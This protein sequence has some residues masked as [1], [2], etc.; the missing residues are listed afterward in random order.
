MDGVGNVAKDVTRGEVE[1]SVYR[2]E[3]EPVDVVFRDP[4]QRVV[5]DE[6]A[7]FVAFGVVVV[8]R[9]SP[10]CRIATREV[11]AVRFEVISLRPDV[12][13]DDVEDAP[14]SFGVRRVDERPQLFRT[15]V[16]ALWRIELDTV[17][18]PVARAWE[19]THRHDLDGSDAELT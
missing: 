7:H 15:A 14:Q 2:V 17:I 19:F 18:A 4:V 3:A 10:G 16:A 9:R 8:E 1:D 11:V 6:A 12:I 13:V 5:D